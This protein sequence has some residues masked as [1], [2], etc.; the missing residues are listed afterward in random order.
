MGGLRDNCGERGAENPPPGESRR[1]IP[2]DQIPPWSVPPGQ[3][4]PVNSPL[5]N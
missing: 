1:P 2:P 5:V 3:F 4:P